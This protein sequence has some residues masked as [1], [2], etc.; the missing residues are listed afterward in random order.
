MDKLIKPIKKITFAYRTVK[1]HFFVGIIVEYSKNFDKTNLTEF[2][3]GFTENRA[4]KAINKYSSTKEIHRWL[5]KLKMYY[6]YWFKDEE[7]I[8]TISDFLDFNFDKLKNI[9]NYTLPINKKKH[10]VLEDKFKFIS[11]EEQRFMIN[12]HKLNDKEIMKNVERFYN[13]YKIDDEI[14][15]K[16]NKE[17][18]EEFGFKYLT[19]RTFLEELNNNQQDIPPEFVEIVDKHFWELF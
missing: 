14:V 3:C 11:I 9:T 6:Y 7:Q 8:K 13:I 19:V 18:E 1:D 17:I 16:W 4:G 2:E 12:M 10:L 15:I 5:C